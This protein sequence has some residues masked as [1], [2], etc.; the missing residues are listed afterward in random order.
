MGSKARHH[1]EVAGEQELGLLSNSKEFAEKAKGFDQYSRQF[2]NVVDDD[3]SSRARGIANVDQNQKVNSPN[4]T[5]NSQHMALGGSA[6]A[7]TV[8]NTKATAGLVDQ[9]NILDNQTKFLGNINQN[10]Q[11]NIANMSRSAEIAA[12]EAGSRA[13][14]SNQKE[15]NKATTSD[16]MTALGGSFLQGAQIRDQMVQNQK[17]SNLL[18]VGNSGLTKANNYG[19]VTFNANEGPPVHHRS[20]VSPRRS[21]LGGFLNDIFRPFT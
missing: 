9:L 19:K 7:G 8:E 6:Y 13:D 3:S 14:F 17:L 15:L 5:P 18:G 4:F 1:A 12:A 16:Y 2:A 20:F 11:N 21:S 10:Q